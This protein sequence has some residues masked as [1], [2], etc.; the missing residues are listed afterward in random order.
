[1]KII[2]NKTLPPKGFKAINLFE[3]VFVRQGSIL[4]ARIIRHESIHSKQMRE[5]L[6]LFFYLWY[7]IE[8]LVR[9]IQYRNAMKAYYNISLER[10]AYANDRKENYP[11][12]RRFWAFIHYLNSI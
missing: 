4:T 2:F 5:M 8:W 3:F 7:G 9:L 6:Y 1:M 12:E 11:T 10:E